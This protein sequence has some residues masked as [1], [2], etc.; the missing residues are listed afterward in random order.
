MSIT[1]KWTVT[2]PSL[3]N[4]F[5]IEM[6]LIELYILHILQNVIPDLEGSLGY[7]DTV[8][9]IF[10]KPPG[11]IGCRIGETI[12][13][14]EISNRINEVRVDLKDFLI[15]PCYEFGLTGQIP[16]DFF[17]NSGSISP[18]NPFATTY[19][20]IMEFDSWDNFISAYN[21]DEDIIQLFSNGNTPNGL[22]WGLTYD[23]EVFENGVPREFV[24]KF[25]TL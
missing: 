15:T 20:L 6:S 25:N 1:Y 3:E 14:E 12:S 22:N 7:P 4:S 21:N 13:W 9:Q 10:N 5:T 16:L 2:K 18:F 24:G 23:E 8:L 17:K 19:T 11:Y